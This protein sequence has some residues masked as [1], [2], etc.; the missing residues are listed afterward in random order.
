M[1]L[2]ARCN[3]DDAIGGLVLEVRHVGIIMGYELL[4]VDMRTVEVVIGVDL[5]H[6]RHIAVTVV[7]GADLRVLQSFNIQC[8]G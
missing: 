2:C 5:E 1:G 6:P 4:L 7:D 3:I 8:R